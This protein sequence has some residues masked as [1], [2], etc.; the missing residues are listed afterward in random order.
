MCFVTEMTAV[1]EGV[2]E[3]GVGEVAEVEAQQYQAN[4]HCEHFF[5]PHYAFMEYR[6]D[7]EKI[8]KEP[9]RFVS[10]VYGIIVVAIII[11]AIQHS[12]DHH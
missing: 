6:A 10:W 1:V 9:T 5:M 8:G 3:F 2:A 11:S 4:R 12:P 7:L